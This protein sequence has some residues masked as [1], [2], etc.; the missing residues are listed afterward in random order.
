MP[1]RSKRYLLSLFVA[2]DAPTTRA[3]AAVIAAEL[4]KITSDDFG[5]EI[6]DVLEEPERAEREGV[7]ATPML[8]KNRPSPPLR[9]LG[10]L[11]DVNQLLKILQIPEEER[12]DAR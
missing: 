12:G 2:G 7:F 6:I 1:R 5:L 10:D 4:G 8:V 9:V 11:T 3:A